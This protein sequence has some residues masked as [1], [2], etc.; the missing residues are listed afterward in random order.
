MQV[1]VDRNTDIY[2]WRLG[3]QKLKLRCKSEGWGREAHG[4]GIYGGSVQDVGL[5]MVKIVSL[6]SNQS[7]NAPERHDLVIYV[8]PDIDITSI[9]F[10]QLR[11]REEC[12]WNPGLSYVVW[13]VGGSTK[14]GS[15]QPAIRGSGWASAF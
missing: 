14:G 11:H 10:G 4:N 13:Q 8:L 5:L 6:E 2:H 7:S 1:S 3:P 9:V 15:L 12:A